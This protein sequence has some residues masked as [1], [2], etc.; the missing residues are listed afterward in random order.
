MIEEKAVYQFLKEDNGKKYYLV[1]ESKINRSKR[2]PAKKVFSKFDSLNSF[3]EFYKGIVFLSVSQELLS[4]H[5][6]IC[7]VQINVGMS[8]ISLEV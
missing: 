5:D 2:A 8:V 6:V 1:Q 3:L 4:L 7:S